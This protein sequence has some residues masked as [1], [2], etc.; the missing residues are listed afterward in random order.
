MIDSCDHHAIPNMGVL[1]SRIPHYV[2]R[3]CGAKIEMTPQTRRIGLVVRI[4][5]YA[6]L[7]FTALFG[8]DIFPGP[9]ATTISLSVMGGIILCFAILQMVLLRYGKFQAAAPDIAGTADTPETVAK[10][11]YT[12]EQLELMALYDSY[13][14]KNA[15]VREED[16]NPPAPVEAAPLPMH[17]DCDHVP[18]KSWKN[19]VPSVYDFT[20]EKCG[21]RI[22]FSAERKK[23]LNLILLAFSG[24]MILSS[25]T[26]KNLLMGEFIAIFAATIVI[27]I[28]VQY[29]FVKKSTFEEKELE[30]KK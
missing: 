6:L 28:G 21:K 29:Y 14:E 9:N 4:L 3:T 2:C 1:F 22:T 20:C 23:R 19:Y 26:L 10:P 5:F 27:C 18:A 17:I 8:K 13:V 24:V 7:L 16:L 12:P 11:Q 30:Q 15:P 25:F